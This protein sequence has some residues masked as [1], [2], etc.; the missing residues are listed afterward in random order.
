[1]PIAWPQRRQRNRCRRLGPGAHRPER[2]D[3]DPYGSGDGPHRVH[4]GCGTRTQNAP[5]VGRIS[6]PGQVAY[7]SMRVAIALPTLVVALVK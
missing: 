4:Q 6:I 1:M 7:F 5:G 2:Y 3:Q